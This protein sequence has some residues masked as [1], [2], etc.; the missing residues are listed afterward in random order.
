MSPAASSDYVRPPRDANL[1]P[2][3]EVISLRIY[4]IKSCRGIE[5]KETRLKM[6]GLDLD[7]NWMFVDAETMTFLTIRSDPT[8]TLID[9]AVNDKD[10]TL[11]ISIHGTEDSV[12]I[13]AHPKQDWLSSN[14]TLEKVEIWGE[15]TDGWTYSNKIND[16][17][18]RYFKKPVKLIYKGPTPRPARGNAKKDLSGR[19]VPHMFADLMSVQIASDSSLRDLNRRLKENDYDGQKLTIERFRPNIVIRGNEPWEEDSWK[20]VQISTADHE[21]QLLW[22]V[23]L[24]VM[25]RCARCQVPNVNPDTAEKHKHEPWDTLMKFRRVDQGGAAKYKPCFGMLCLPTKEGPIKVGS[26]FEVNSMTDK[27][28]YNEAKFQDL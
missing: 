26:K 21:N 5:V 19:E 12:T 27:H 23:N 11:T 10:D 1:P 3:S 9:T 6:S 4:P 17:F 7:R 16:M 14:N 18:S 28:L 22:R 24:D 8:M 15:K 2:A 25:C 13:P 20:T